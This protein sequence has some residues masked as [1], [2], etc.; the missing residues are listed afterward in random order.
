MSEEHD[1]FKQ[2]VRVRPVRP[3]DIERL[4][5]AASEDNHRVLAPTHVVTKSDEIV[6]YLSLGAVPVVHVW[7]DT[8]KVKVRDTLAVLTTME[9]I[10]SN[11]GWGLICLPCSDQ[12]P[13]LPF[14]DKFGYANL[15]KMN[16]CIKAL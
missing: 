3:E 7:M 5:H 12:S 6:G 11:K 13:Y 15:G 4:Q 16:F 10:A 14:M 8:K 9:N 1:V 2:F